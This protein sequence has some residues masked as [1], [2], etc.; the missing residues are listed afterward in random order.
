M[1]IWRNSAGTRKFAVLGFFPK[2]EINSIF[3]FA[4]GTDAS[5]FRTIVSTLFGTHLSV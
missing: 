1:T 5:I 2:A 4:D 3:L